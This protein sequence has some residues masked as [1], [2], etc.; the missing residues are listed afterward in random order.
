MPAPL[1]AEAS[2]HAPRP[3]RAST[4]AAAG[5]PRNTGTPNRSC[6][7]PSGVFSSAGSPGG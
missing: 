4:N 1:A 5:M 2:R 6:A 7:L 3:R